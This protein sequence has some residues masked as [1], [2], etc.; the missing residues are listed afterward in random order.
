MGR[1]T[2]RTLLVGASFTIAALS[3]AA[4]T[5]AQAD[6]DA[7]WMP[8]IGC[9]EAVGADDQLGLLCFDFDGAGVELTNHVAGQAASTEQLVADESQR[10][11]SVEGCEGWESVSFS[12]DGRRAFTQTEFFCGTEEARTGT[13][14][15]TFVAPNQWSDVRVLDVGGEEVAWVQ[16]YRLVG[17]DRLA[18]QGLTDPAE[19]LGMAVRS[20]RMAAAAPIDLGDVQEALGRMDDKAVET[21]IVAQ[22]DQ[23]DPDAA[24]LIGL[25]DAGAPENVIDAVV[26][27]SHPDRFVVEAAGPIEEVE[28]EPRATHYR[29]YMG[30]NPFYGSRLGVR[31]GYGYG[32]SPFGLGYSPWAYDYGYGYGYWGSRPGRVI[33][34]RRPSNGG[35]W[36]NDRGYI[37]RSGRTSTGRT[38]RPRGD[39]GS[40]SFSTGSGSSAGSAAPS[41]GG[42]RSTPR[43]AKRR[44][45]GGNG[46]L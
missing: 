44:R 36:D 30:Y 26:A 2:M 45:G 6:G 11:V 27:V 10:P 5:S 37:P 7:R 46:G 31:Y 24:D 3:L 21:W 42:S 19:G 43:K 28:N 12:E 15:M 17:A 18:E 32:Y 33:I 29:G 23:L 39:A 14:V 20:A 16:E 4:P 9:W 35:R 38:A 40:P 41:S 22:Q 1:M 8:F 25:A 34:E 13:G